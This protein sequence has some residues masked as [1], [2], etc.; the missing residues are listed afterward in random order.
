MPSWGKSE[1]LS[2]KDTIFIWSLTFSKTAST[3]G[4]KQ[5]VFVSFFLL[6]AAA[7]TAFRQH[8]YARNYRVKNFH[9]IIL[10]VK[11][12]KNVA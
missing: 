8:C 11:F 2:F 10:K 1:K 9:M 5:A 12:T 7:A 6:L 3:R 4:L